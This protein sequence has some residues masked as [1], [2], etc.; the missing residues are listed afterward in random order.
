VKSIG[1]LAN[2]RNPDAKATLGQLA[3]RA[4]RLG[5]RLVACDDTARLTPGCRRVATAG[6]RAELDAVMVLGG[7]GTML[8]AVGLLGGADV[9]I[10]GVNLGSLGFMTSAHEKQ[11]VQ[12]LTALVRG[13]YTVSRR[14][15]MEVAVAKPGGR[16]A[17]FDALNDAVIAWG[18]SSR[19]HSFDVSIDGEPITTYRCDGIIVSTPT[20]STGH[21]MSAG[22]PIVHPATPAFLLHVICPHT[23][24]TR[25]LV[26]PDSATLEIAVTSTHSRLLLSVDGRQERRL[27][28]GARVTIRKSSRSVTFAH[29]P[30]YSYFGVLR[31][32]LH[33]RGSSLN[34]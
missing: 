32:K 25:P 33:W 26:V 6:M 34:P 20:G 5:V 14:D 29:L 9:P 27:L 22:G 30:G 13:R 31:E 8:A 28:H 2:T 17:R 16:P 7:D 18:A 15:L 1:V 11:A 4:A 12:G 3:A 10:L 24:S 23:L 19:I 21:A